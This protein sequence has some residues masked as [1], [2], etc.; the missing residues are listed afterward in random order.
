MKTREIVQTIFKAVIFFGLIAAAMNL[1]QSESHELKI[2]FRIILDLGFLWYGNE[3]V[4]I[5]LNGSR[6]K[7]IK[8]H[9]MNRTGQQ[10]RLECANQ[11]IYELWDEGKSLKKSED[12]LYQEWDQRVIQRLKQ[13]YGPETLHLYLIATER[14][15]DCGGPIRPIEESVLK[16]AVLL[17]RNLL[18]REH[19]G[20]SATSKKDIE[21]KKFMVPS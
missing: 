1:F 13:Y 16:K 12:H 3:I 5:T 14:S 10:A 7:E 2:I 17:L 11:I 8:E 4:W 19:D 6:E 15:G 21:V 9:R 18:C 20:S